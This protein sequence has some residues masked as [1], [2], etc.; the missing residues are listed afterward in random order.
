MQRD[1]C[2]DTHQLLYH[3]ELCLLLVFHRLPKVH[4]CPDESAQG[5]GQSSKMFALKVVT[6][7]SD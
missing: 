1:G 2:L 7:T 6:T 3:N 5:T 4:T